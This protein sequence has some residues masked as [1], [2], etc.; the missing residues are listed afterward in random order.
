MMTRFVLKVGYCKFICSCKSEPKSTGHSFG[1]VF[2]VS[3]YNVH[4]IMKTE[5]KLLKFLKL[6]KVCFFSADKRIA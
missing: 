2:E 4:C 1:P 5:R 3:L 6:L